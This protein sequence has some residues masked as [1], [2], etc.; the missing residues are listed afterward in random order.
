MTIK[1]TPTEKPS[2]N[3]EHTIQVEMI[4]LLATAITEQKPRDEI[5]KILNQLLQFSQVH[6]MSEQ[7]I[8]RQHSYDGFDEHENEHGELIDQLQSA[9][10]KLLSDETQ[11]DKYDFNELRGQLLNHI[12]TQDH[13][14]SAFLS[15][16]I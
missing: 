9:K 7:L 8:M 6:F 13:K 1:T 10:K 3:K 12:A 4:T 14:L 15:R 11:L 5:I 16:Q 2:H